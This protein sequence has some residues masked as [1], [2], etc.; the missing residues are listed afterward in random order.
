MVRHHH[1]GVFPLETK[2]QLLNPGGGDRVER[3]G[4]LIHQQ[5]LGLHRKRPRN[6]QPLLLPARKPKRRFA[7]PILDLSP[8]RRLGQRALHQLVQ[9][10][11]FAHAV[12]A[13]AERDILINAHR[14]RIRLLKHHSHTAA[15]G[16]DVGQAAENILSVKQ[17]LSLHT[18]VLHQI[19]HAVQRFEQRGFAA[20]GRADEGGGASFR[21]IQIDPLECLKAAVVQIEILNAKLAHLRF[22]PPCPLR[23]DRRAESAGSPSVS[24]SSTAAVA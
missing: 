1:N 23:R 13:R 19:G 3:R 18:A 6:A 22:P 5:H 14:K 16:V 24:T 12:C 11:L 9:L 21:N 4:R 2:N 8:E 20:S 10:L 15:Q 7:Q 17:H